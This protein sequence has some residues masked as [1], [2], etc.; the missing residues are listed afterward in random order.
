MM[1]VQGYGMSIWGKIVGSVAGLAVGGPLGALLGGIAGHA[2]DKGQADSK[3][4]DA[5]AGDVNSIAFTIAV[6]AL[7]IGRAHV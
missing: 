6:I 1:A 4:S 5:K 3:G 2:Y 7:E